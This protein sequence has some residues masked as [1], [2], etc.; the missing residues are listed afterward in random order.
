LLKKKPSAILNQNTNKENELIEGLIDN[1]D[2]AYETL[3]RQ[4]SDRMYA[5]A[6]RFFILMTMYKSVC[7]NNLFN[8]L[9]ISPHL[10]KIHSSLLGYT[11]LPL[12]KH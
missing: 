9:R 3:V 8:F 1:K 5:V 2:L 11:V 12:V 4:Y 10:E 7:K 6:R